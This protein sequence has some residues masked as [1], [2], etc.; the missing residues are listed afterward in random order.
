MRHL[1][2][3]MQIFGVYILPT[4][5]EL[6]GWSRKLRED[7]DQLPAYL[8]RKFFLS[9][10]RRLKADEKWAQRSA[11]AVLRGFAE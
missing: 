11:I 8:K 2:P 5:F 9:E 3:E 7:I 6:P 4:S 10:I 1:T